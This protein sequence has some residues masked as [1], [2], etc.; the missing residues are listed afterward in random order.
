VNGRT[1][2][3]DTCIGEQKD[4]LEI[5]AWNQR[6]GTGFLEQLGKTGVD[7]AEVEHANS[8]QIVPIRTRSLSLLKGAGDKS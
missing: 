5:P 6:H 7:A 1:I 8:S 2:L 3:V 4:R